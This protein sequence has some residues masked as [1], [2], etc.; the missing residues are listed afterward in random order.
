ML[1]KQIKIYSV[2]TNAFLTKEEQTLNKKIKGMESVIQALKEFTLLNVL[3]D[4]YN[5]KITFV[6][7]P[8][9]LRAYREGHEIE[10]VHIANLLYKIKRNNTV[11]KENKRTKV[12][13]ELLE[14]SKYHFNDVLDLQQQLKESSNRGYIKKYINKIVEANK[15]LIKDN[16]FKKLMRKV[17]GDYSKTELVITT[18]KSGQTNQINKDIGYCASVKQ[19]KKEFNELIRKNTEVRGLDKVSKYNVISVFDSFLMRTLGLEDNKLSEDLITLRVYHYSIFKQLIENGFMYKGEKYIPFTASAGQIRCK[20]M[21]F[22]KEIVW[23]KYQFTLMCGLTIDDINN[24]NEKGCNINKFLAY[25]ALTASATDEWVG[26]DIDQCV[27]L[28]DFETTIKDAKVDYISKT[29]ETKQIKFKNED[30]TFHVKK[31]EYWL[32]ADA[33]KEEVKDVTITH[34]DGCGWILPELSQKNFMVRLPW[35]KGLLTPV[36]F[37][38]WCDKYNDSNY[39]VKDIYGKEWDLKEDNIK[40]V[41][42]KSQ[43][44]MY[45]YYLSWEDYKDKFIKYNCRANKCNEEKDD[46]KNANFNYQMFQTLEKIDDEIIEKF[47]RPVHNFITKAYTDKNT[48]LQLLGATKKNANMNYLQQAVLLYPELLQDKHIKNELS[49]ALN[50][51]KKDAKYGKFKVDAKY[52]FIIPDVVAWMQYVFLGED[53]VTGLLEDQQVYCKLFDTKKYPKLLVNRSPHLYKNEH[54]VRDNVTSEDMKEWFI[55]DGI[56]TSCKDLI[57]KILSFDNDGDTSLVCGDKN[58]I[59]LAEENVEGL[60]PLYY[61]MGKA[62]PKEINSKNIYESLI[63]AFEYG[64]IGEYSNKLTTLWNQREYDAEGREIDF[65][66]EESK[67]RLNLAKIIACMNNF[68]IDAAKTLEMV[69]VSDEVQSKLNQLNKI[70]L[71]YFFQFAKDKDEDQ[72]EAINS[73]TVNRICNKIEGIPQLDYD[74]DDVGKFNKNMLMNNIKIEIIQEVIEKYKELQEEMQK[75]FMYISNFSSVAGNDEELSKE[76]I[77]LLVYD[78][79]YSEL[80]EFCKSKNINVIDATDMIIKHIYKSNP[81]CKKGFLFNVLGDIILANIRNNLKAKIKAKKP[82]SGHI[83]CSKCNKEVLRKGNRQTMCKEC[84]AEVRKVKDRERKS[85]NKSVEIVETLIFV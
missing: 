29:R 80:E 17:D 74:F 53:K 76:R 7:A 27:V 68:S 63:K 10:D 22:I 8:T 39:K 65:T 5:E 19:W 6:E 4:I 35:V 31:E 71:P 23:N 12:T 37:I 60:L 34:S 77:A 32:L 41:F 51:K 55:T 84:S 67:D 18:T 85:K 57:S 11:I 9:G 83:F 82:K 33:A 26:F 56:Y 21:Q 38:S 48:M 3:D 79:L 50:K 47:T 36:D 44:K 40:I 14:K 69:E 15:Q 45:K 70:K 24:S 54:C 52:T 73:S 43:F 81:E 61:E 20:K 64:N 75:Y 28:D 78:S 1:N 42:F 2:D 13:E 46:F 59:R 62:E 72:V 30:G 66:E 49:E 16:A 25:L 58:L